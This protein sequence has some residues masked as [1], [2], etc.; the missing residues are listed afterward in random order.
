MENKTILSVI[1][2]IIVAIFGYAIFK[3][4][5]NLKI[6]E[7][8]SD[9][10]IETEEVRKV[11]KTIDLKYKYQEGKNIFVGTIDL[12]NSCD[13][14]S[15]EISDEGIEKQ[16]DLLIK[17]NNLGENCEETEIQKTFRIEILGKKDEN[18]LVTLNGELINL[19]ISPI[20]ENE[21][22]DEIETY[23]KK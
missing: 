3:N 15:A 11:Q 7:E 21:D 2:L 5:Q 1:F 17:E 18:V 12:K 6:T 19:N 8:I 16:I 20:S 22:I 10:N 9:K 14:F 13:K 23:E 4:N